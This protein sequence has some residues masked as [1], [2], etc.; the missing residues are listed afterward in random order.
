MIGRTP[1]VRTSVSTAVWT[2][3]SAALDATA[4]RVELSAL[5]VAAF[6]ASSSGN[7]PR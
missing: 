6:T 2:S 7:H 4:T 3:S 1:D 5:T